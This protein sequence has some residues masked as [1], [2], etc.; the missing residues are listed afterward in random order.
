MKLIYSGY[1]RLNIE[2]AVL[3]NIHLFTYH[4]IWKPIPKRERRENSPVTSFCLNPLLKKNC[5]KSK[6]ANIDE[7]DSEV[8][9]NS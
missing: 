1:N 8:S 6:R 7:Y 3:Y 5:G 4:I 2:S 9:I